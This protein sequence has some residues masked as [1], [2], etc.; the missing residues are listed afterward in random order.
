MRV[1]I[2]MPIETYL[3]CTTRLPASSRECFLMKNGI[4]DRET[5]G[6]EILEF[7]C[8]SERAKDLLMR[9]AQVCPEVLQNIK[10]RLDMPR[11]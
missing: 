4:I 7:L 5:E 3:I 1:N 10:H 8:D 9:V 11:G 2:K 6:N